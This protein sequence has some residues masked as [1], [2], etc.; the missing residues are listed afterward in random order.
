MTRS[1]AE[2]ARAAFREHYGAAPTV[3]ARAPGRVNLIGEHTDYNDGFALPCAIDRETVVAARARG[4]AIVQVLATDDE[5]HVDRFSLK[6]PLAPVTTPRWSNYVRGVIAALSREG[7]AIGGADLA[8]A[9]NIPQGTG[10]SSSASLE[11]AVGQALKMLFRLDVTPTALAV[12]GQR[13]E[14][15]FAG[16]MCGI[17][18]Q[19]VSAHGRAGHAL[20]LD[21]RSLSTM[22]V[23]LPEGAA[24][25][26]IDSRIARGLVDSEYNL[27][28]R[29]CEQAAA[30]FGVR[31]LRD[32]SEARLAAE[33]PALDPLLLRRARHVI[34]ENARTLEAAQALRSGDLSRM[35][36]LMRASH[37]S[38]RDDFEVSLPAI[39]ALVGT[40]NAVV[41]EAGGA[42]MTGGGFGGCVVA[43]A[44]STLAGEIEAAVARHYRSPNGEAAV[45]HHCRAADGAGPA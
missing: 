10:L 37:A 6:E 39:D 25:V 1:P 26:I 31:A 16:C 38:L 14:H 12:A 43:L 27:R 5:A 45:V 7:H 30:H 9:G 15:E 28:R 22:P 19:L 24:V 29:Q 17:M 32:V 20:L 21:C 13:A 44:P 42:R 23:P 2:R 34:G 8:I 18:D 33:A 3:T 40:V 35:G 41:G 11:M 4:D 36:Q